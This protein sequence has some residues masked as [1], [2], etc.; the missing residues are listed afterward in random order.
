MILPRLSGRWKRPHQETA[1]TQD[2]KRGTQI[3]LEIAEKGLEFLGFCFFLFVF[4]LVLICFGGF[5]GGR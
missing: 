4:F 5:F 2:T 3:A 1:K